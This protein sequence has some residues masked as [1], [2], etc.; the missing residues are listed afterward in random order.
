MLIPL[1]QKNQKHKN[2]K[3]QQHQ[4]QKNQKELILMEMVQFKSTIKM[5]KVVVKVMEITM[6][7]PTQQTKHQN[8]PTIIL[9]ELP[10]LLVTLLNS[11]AVM[12][13]KPPKK[14]PQVLTVLKTKKTKMKVVKDQLTDVAQTDKPKNPMTDQTV[15]EI[16]QPT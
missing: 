11:N 7:E 1:N 12:M 5:T 8:Q 4:N 6:K 3:N 2:Q 9:T 14:M 10:M 15:Q 16:P 13:K